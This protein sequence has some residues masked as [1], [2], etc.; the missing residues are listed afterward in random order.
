MTYNI[1]YL[2]CSAV[3]SPTLL[4]IRITEFKD[5]L[6]FKIFN[7]FQSNCVHYIPKKFISKTHAQH[8]SMQSA[9]Y[10]YTWLKYYAY[11]FKQKILW[12]SL[13]RDSCNSSFHQST[14]KSFFFH[15]LH[16]ELKNVY[17]QTS[18]EV[19]LLQMTN[20][21]GFIYSILILTNFHLFCKTKIR[22]TW[23][24]K[25]RPILRPGSAQ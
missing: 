15:L 11:K 24:V 5:L 4:N 22:N 23:K 7:Q 16:T 17:Y 2:D 13:A 19:T 3:N 8:K 14:Q 10:Y 9:I 21:M 25:Q 6:K 1:P 20:F 12:N 18:R